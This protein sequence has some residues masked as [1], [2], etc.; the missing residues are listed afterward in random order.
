[1]KLKHDDN[2]DYK[3]IISMKMHKN[4]QKKIDNDQIKVSKNY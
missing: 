3:N 4:K 2:D 1:M